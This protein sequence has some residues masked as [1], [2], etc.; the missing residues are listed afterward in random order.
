LAIV[1]GSELEAVAEVVDVARLE[2]VPGVDAEEHEVV[3]VEVQR[4]A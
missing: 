2:E 4:E 3:E 1:V